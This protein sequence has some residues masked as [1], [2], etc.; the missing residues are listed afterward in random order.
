[1]SGNE[2]KA[3][4]VHLEGVSL[5]YGK[6]RALDGVSLDIPSGLM[7]GFIGPDG[8]GKSSL[9]SLIS[10][11]RAVQ[12]GTVDVLGGGMT[13]K[14]H[15][16]KVGPLIAYMPQGLGKNLYP[17]LSVEENLQ[18]FARLFGHDA[19]ERRRRI[20]YL[21]RSTGLNEFLDRPAGK[22]SGGMKQKLG[23]CSSL[24]HDPDLLILDEPTTGV[25][26]LA[27][28][29][30]WDLIGR[31]RKEQPGMSVIVA[32]AYMDEAE[33][34]DWLVAMDDGKILDTG[35][36][37]ELLEKTG[38]DSLES[39]FIKLLPEEKRE[40]YE[41]VEIKP[42]DL[43]QDDDVAIEAKGLTKKF[44]DFVAVD[45]VTFRIRKGEIF[46]FLGSN[47]SG[48]STTMKIL[49]GLLPATEGQAWLFG[50]EVDSEDMETRRNVG[51]MSQ[52]FSLY[53]ELTVR[54]NLVLHARLFHVPED[55]IPGRVEEMSKRFDLMKIQDS[56]PDNLPL[57]VRQRLS[58]AVAMVH[59]PGLLILDEPTSGVDPIARD[60]FW[61]FM[62][63]LSR[64]DKVTIFISTHFMNEAERCDRISLMHAGKV[65]ASDPP[66]ELVEKSGAKDLEAAFIQYLKEAGDGA[67]PEGEG[68][69]RVAEGTEESKEET[70]KKA[71][72]RFSPGRMLSY[73][74]RESL[75]LKRDPVRT[76][77]ALLGSIILMLVIGF[78]ISMDVNELSYAVLDRDQTGLSNN[79]ALNISGSRYFIEQP[80]VH[81]YAELDKR[82]RSG[83]LSLV[84]EIPPG[85]ARK[86]Q[87][88]DPV[89][90]GAWVDGA[91]PQRAETIQGYVRGMH[92]EWLV[93]QAG[94]RTG[95]AP[96]ALADIQVRFRY[97]PDVE[98]LPA[99]VPA[100][101][102][103]LLLMLP[104][105]LAAL[106]VVR[107]KELGSIIN[108]YVTPVTRTEF[109]LGKQIPYVLLAMLN[110]FLMVLLSVTAFDV[111]VKG[112]FLTLTVAAFL[113][114][115]IATGMGLLASTFTRSQIAAMFITMIGTI[116]PAVQ[117]SGMINST[118]SL[119]GMGKLVGSIYPTTHMLIIS[120]G[121]FNKALG[122]GDLTGAMGMLAITFPLILAL[123]IA[124][125][126][127]QET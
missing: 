85:F 126:K 28:A 123:S 118:S 106:S 9:L 16:D 54:Q 102:P 1:M 26:P 39:A 42:L 98:S 117:F 4:V 11:A 103:I 7:I 66:V 72:R 90:V 110:F 31:V 6:T 12:E 63:D 52:A 69:T 41:P 93:A 76:T 60:N 116:L 101:I 122:F 95:S 8:V 21:T 71:E 59:K 34:F 18:F 104:S 13:E 35:S 47:G 65:L 120:R 78:G 53:S 68:E 121:V 77:L 81:D 2:S 107:E 73:T 94:S 80:P 119:E 97:N 24:I 75:E 58:L 88:G 33:R 49:T 3:P 74:W 62:I 124:L 40:G 55:E 17:M 51:Y 61:R 100:V 29:Q 84:I 86:F 38:S 112:S 56:L 99:M 19:E 14:A 32:T 57:G 83:K 91:M 114:C 82:M 79:Y 30:F 20:D 44:G 36:P 108:L 115:L 105:M 37:E 46:G 89:E 96:S 27:R 43:G 109:L 127:K 15:R 48:K 87:R 92:Q 25:D 111:P 113:Y 23:L 64:N 50:N 67:E 22:L 125:L 10:G 5:H 70:L 45:H